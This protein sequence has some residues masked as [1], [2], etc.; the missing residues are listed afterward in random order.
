MLF[1]IV[2]ACLLMLATTDKYWPF[3]LDVNFWNSQKMCWSKSGKY[4]G[5]FIIVTDVL[6]KNSGAFLWRK[7]QASCESSGVSNTH[8]ATIF[9][10]NKA[11]PLF[12]LV[13]ETKKEQV[14]YDMKTAI[15][16]LGLVIGMSFCLGDTDISNASFGIS[17]LDHVVNI[18]NILSSWSLYP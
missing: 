1:R 15:S 6:A 3:K 9:P 14:P 13:Q 2:I 11:A 18:M 16:S 4:G 12:D 7:T 8:H 17:F 10:S 5:W